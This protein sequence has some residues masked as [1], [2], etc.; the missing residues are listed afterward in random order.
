MHQASRRSTTP[1]RDYN[2]GAGAGLDGRLAEEA[3][4]S[5][6]LPSIDGRGGTAAPLQTDTVAEEEPASP[7]ATA[8]SAT[9]SVALKGAATTTTMSFATSHDAGT[10]GS[11]AAAHKRVCADTNDAPSCSSRLFVVIRA[12]NTSLL[13]K[14]LSATPQERLLRQ[15]NARTRCCGRTPLFLAVELNDLASCALL[16]A[17]KADPSLAER[18]GG[19]TPLYSACEH[20]YRGVVELLISAAADVNASTAI[21]ASPLHVACAK[22]HIECVEMLL[23]CEPAFSL[24]AQPSEAH[25]TLGFS[26]ASARIAGAP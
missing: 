12:A 19:K 23:E 5:S 15:L 18:P 20:D 2:L 25:T 14:A 7:A 4:P 26:S 22:Q 24:S 6:L 21:G 13:S 17:A 3:A 11:T 1:A 8:M 9:T 16:I 10:F